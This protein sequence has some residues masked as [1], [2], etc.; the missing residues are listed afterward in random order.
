MKIGIDLDGVLASFDGGVIKLANELLPGKIPE[1]YK[2]ADWDWTDVLTK[3]DWDVLWD[4]I[5]GTENF[6]QHLDP[7]TENILALRRFL[8][9][10]YDQ[11]IYFVTSRAT[12]KGRPIAV[13]TNIWLAEQKIHSGGNYTSIIPVGNSKNKPL[14]YKALEINVSVDDYGRTVKQTNE[15]VPGHTA[16]ILDRSWNRDAEYGPRV[17]NLEEFFKEIEKL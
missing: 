8:Y 9:R 13:Q 17:A 11:E 5:N 3:K 6:W 7:Y 16:Y 1:G 15:E 4:G 10:N 2:P 12:G 14:V